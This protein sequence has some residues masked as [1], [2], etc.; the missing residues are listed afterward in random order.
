MVRGSMSLPVAT[1][2]RWQEVAG[3][4]LLER[5][6]MTETLMTLTNPLDGDRIPGMDFFAILISS[7]K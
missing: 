3:I 5:Y 7:L 1:F 2:R 4:T 6:G